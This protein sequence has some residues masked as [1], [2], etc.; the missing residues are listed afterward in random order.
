MCA[1]LIIQFNAQLNENGLLTDFFI[2]V[3]LFIN[4]CLRVEVDKYFY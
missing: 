3:V 4:S 2:P 1:A